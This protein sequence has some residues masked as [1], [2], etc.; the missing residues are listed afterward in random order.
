MKLDGLFSGLKLPALANENVK[1]RHGVDKQSLRAWV[2][3]EVDV[4]FADAP[5]TVFA[6]GPVTLRL[7]NARSSER[8]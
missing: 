7:L 8:R 5:I 2:E 4:P 3:S 6:F 1:V